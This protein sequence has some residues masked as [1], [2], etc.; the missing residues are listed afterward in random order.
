MPRKA[1]VFSSTGIY[2]ITLRSVNQQ[3]IFED[4]SDYQKFLY[5]LS[6]SIAKYNIDIYAYCLMSNHVHL[7]LSASPDLLST[8]FQSIETRFAHWYNNK[9][10]RSGY[11]FQ[12][13]FHSFAVEDNAYF[14]NVL[15][16][17]HNNPV[18]AGICGFPY[19]YRWSSYN[20]YY[21]EENSLVNAEFANSIVG[22]KKALLEY[23]AENMENEEIEKEQ[24]ERDH[25]QNRHYLSDEQA[26]E[27]IRFHAGDIGIHQIVSCSK[28]KRDELVL[29]LRRKGLNVKQISRL[30]GI[31]RPTINTIC[32]Q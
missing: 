7:L 1:R 19:E 29:I 20:A 25:P 4:D 30:T 32:N 18:S 31:S 23:F 5:V 27:I 8:F 28:S 26:L 17:I 15:I 13:R 6:D 22:S 3:I 10:I 2:H 24:F 14:L 21:G 9:Y 16:Y 11:L 12:D